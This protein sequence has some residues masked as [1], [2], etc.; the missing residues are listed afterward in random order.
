[1]KA[2]N[3][4]LNACRLCMEESVPQLVVDSGSAPICVT[5]AVAQSPPEVS[6]FTGHAK[7]F[8]MVVGSQL[9]FPN[10][11]VLTVLVASRR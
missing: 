10:P 2:A 9:H 6:C 11:N 7:S 5:Q 4:S 3:P 8:S 1:M